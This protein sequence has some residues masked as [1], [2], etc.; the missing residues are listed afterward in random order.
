MNTPREFGSDSARRIGDAL[1]LDW[2][3]VDLEQFLW[4]L[5]VEL[6]HGTRG[7]LKQT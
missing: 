2:G 4:A 3:Q 1:G 7:F 6:E 5:Q